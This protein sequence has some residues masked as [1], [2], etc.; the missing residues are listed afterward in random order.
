MEQTQTNIEEQNFRVNIK[1]TAKGLSYFDVTARGQTEIE[2]NER[3]QKII[4]IAKTM[5]EELNKNVT[6]E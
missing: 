1:Q 2:V 4:T 6:E 5:C 3:L